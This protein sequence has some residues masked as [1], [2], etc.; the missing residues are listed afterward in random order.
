MTDFGRIC[1]SVEMLQN[2]KPPIFSWE[3]EVAVTTVLH[4]TAPPVKSNSS[5]RLHWLHYHRPSSTNLTESANINTSISWLK[6]NSKNWRKRQ[7]SRPETAGVHFGFSEVEACEA[8]RYCK[9]RQ[10]FN[11]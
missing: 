8:I 11:Y 10:F 6:I 4:Y 3:T 7:W 5:C 9:S 1:L 2:Y